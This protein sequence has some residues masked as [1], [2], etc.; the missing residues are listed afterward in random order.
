[1]IQVNLEH[2]TIAVLFSFK[3]LICSPDVKKSKIFNEFAPR[4]PPPE[5]PSGLPRE[6]GAEL[7]ALEDAYL[8]VKIIS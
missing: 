4:S 3:H 7:T 1:M 5:P 6:P 2:G 8:D